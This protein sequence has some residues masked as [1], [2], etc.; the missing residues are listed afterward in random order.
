[1]TRIEQRTIL[2]AAGKRAAKKS[3]TTKNK[4]LSD[5]LVTTTLRDRFDREVQKLEIGAMPIELAKQ[6]D[7]NAQSF[8]RVQI[9]RLPDV[10]VGELLSEA[11]ALWEEGGIFRTLYPK[12]PVVT[13]IT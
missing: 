1:M 7:R 2:T 12:L 9:V 8:S 4:D 11:L 5:R 10:P 6:R 13:D 3:I